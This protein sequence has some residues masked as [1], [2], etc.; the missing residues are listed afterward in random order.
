MSQRTLAWWASP[1]PYLSRLTGERPNQIVLRICDMSDEQLHWAISRMQ[2][3][4]SKEMLLSGKHLARQLI[5]NYM[6]EE[7]L[8]RGH[9]LV[10][11][12]GYFAK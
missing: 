1:T 3:S 9:G 5:L 10:D 7:L 8:D 2:L 4:I 6:I 11:I 12:P